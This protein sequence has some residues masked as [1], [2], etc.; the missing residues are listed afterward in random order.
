[1]SIKIVLPLFIDPVELEDKIGKDQ[2]DVW[3]VELIGGDYEK[4][5]EMRRNN[6]SY[7][8]FTPSI[9]QYDNFHK[10]TNFWSSVTDLLTEYPAEGIYQ[11][12]SNDIVSAFK[13]MIYNIYKPEENKLEYNKSLKRYIIP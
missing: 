3:K 13:S 2:L 10:P 7:F 9:E 1:M 5:K 11:F 4:R 6:I 12:N 8:C